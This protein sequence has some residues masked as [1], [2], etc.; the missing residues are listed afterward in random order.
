M[1]MQG[2]LHCHHVSHAHAQRPHRP[3]LLPTPDTHLLAA[4]TGRALTA[5]RLVLLATAGR[6]VRA[7]VVLAELVLGAA[8]H[9]PPAATATVVALL[10]RADR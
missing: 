8:E 1:H 4:A 7:A 9:G 3:R 2:T 5:A 10:A 6:A